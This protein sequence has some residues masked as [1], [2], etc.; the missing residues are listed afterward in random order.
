[1]K[2][3]LPFLLCVGLCSCVRAQID[4]LSRTE[5]VH[6]LRQ[7]RDTILAY[8][9]LAWTPSGRAGIDSSYRVTNQ[10]LTRASFP[11][12]RLDF[13]E[14]LGP[15]IRGTGD[16]HLTF[17]MS[18][19]R[20]AQEREIPFATYPL[21]LSLTEEGEIVLRRAAVLH[22]RT[23][24]PGTV[25]RSINGRDAASFIR[26]LEQVFP[27]GDHG[28][29]AGSRLEIAR[30]LPVLNQAFFG[31]TDT[32]RLL[33]SYRETD[34]LVS[35]APTIELTDASHPPEPYEIEK[36]LWYWA[37]PSFSL[38]K[39]YSVRRYDREL[40]RPRIQSFFRARG[41]ILDLRGNPGGS[42]HLAEILYAYLT[43]RPFKLV[44]QVRTRTRYFEADEAGARRE[45]SRHALSHDNG[46]T[47]AR[48]QSQPPMG[49]RHR[50]AGPLVVLTDEG[51]YSV[52]SL[53]ANAAREQRRATIV[54]ATGGGSRRVVYAWRNRTFKLGPDE[55]LLLSV[56]LWKADVRSGGPLLVV[57][58]ESI[59]RR[60][61]DF[62][63]GRDAALEAALRY[64]RAGR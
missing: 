7:F 31:P 1:M 48:P 5:A 33:T 61:A 17:G 59:P 41:L 53:L 45:M 13:A 18:R 11:L 10:R 3:F 51:T 55:R 35:V 34:D 15:F 37:M 64:L 12:H 40:L 46:W 54:G 47:V 26:K 27:A 21:D 24:P 8:H 50:Y 60:L 16:G 44:R 19:R 39:G 56:P 25:V 30:L 43:D 58:D 20:D 14:Y 32:L 42:Y 38:P 9:P 4:S 57:P 23:L 22:D 52:A 62:Q 36:G 6:T 2:P 28:Y 29:V 49:K 63:E